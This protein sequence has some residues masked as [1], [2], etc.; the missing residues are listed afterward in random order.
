MKAIQDHY[1]NSF[2]QCY[3]CGYQNAHGHQIKTHWNGEETITRYTPEAHHTAIPGVVYG[4]VLASIIDCHG[5]G[6]GSLAIAKERNLKVE[7]DN[8]PRCVTA[9]LLVKY[10]KPTPLGPE[11]QIVGKIREVKGRKVIVDAELYANGI[12]TVS[13]EIIVVE[14]PEGF[15]E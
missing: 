6:S 13:G 8:A 15:G 2:A 11:L 1:S 3:G 7:G 14:V 12:M 4:G 9:S 5:T 10:H